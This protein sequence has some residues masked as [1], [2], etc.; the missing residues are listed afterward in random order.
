MD[1]L[2]Y[3]PTNGWFGDAMP[4]YCNGRYHIYYTKLNEK[5]KICWGH[6]S[7]TDLV[8]YTEHPDPFSK[9]SRG[10]DFTGCVTFANDVFH[11]YYTGNAADGRHAMYHAESP[12]GELFMH[13]DDV[14]FFRPEEWYLS[15]RTFRDP[16]V[17]YD[18]D[19]KIYHMVYC[20]KGVPQNKSEVA[21]PGVIGHAVSSDLKK[22]ENLPPLKLGGIASTAECPELFKYENRWALIYY[23]HETRFRT[24]DSLDAA[25]IR[26]DVISPDHFDFMAGR[27]MF[28]GERHILVGWIPRRDCDCAERIWGGNMLIP[29]ELFFKN[30]IT[31]A[32]RFVR[33]VKQMFGKKSE[34]FSPAEAILSHSGASATENGIAFNT[35]SVGAAALWERLPDECY[36][37][38]DVEMS[39]RN[40]TVIFILSSPE[41]EKNAKDQYENGYALI[42]DPSEGLVRLRRHY[43]WDQRND[44]AVIP[45]TP[46]LD[47][48]FKVEIIRHGGIIEVGINGEQTLVSR[49]LCDC[50]SSLSV[51]AHDTDAKIHSLEVY[52]R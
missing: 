44:I 25:W 42:I 21:Y 52:T 26:G 4:L 3:K 28:D 8:N 29:R 45:F 13:T 39:D 9:S 41:T 37:C 51:C 2:H 7:S 32:T 27:H 46:R 6:I 15:D 23:W 48:P 1:F 36:I 5:N 18:E 12:D 50:G 35:D 17:F 24:A 14:C 38:A 30:G 33:E 34:G 47:Q 49:L 19:E 11:A 16:H 10:T 31:P 40:G 20:V 43:V 22:W